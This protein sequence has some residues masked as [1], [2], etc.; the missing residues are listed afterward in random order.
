MICYSPTG[1]TKLIERLRED[2]DIEAKFWGDRMK[3]S[4]S[5]SLMTNI[6]RQQWNLYIVAANHAI[7][8]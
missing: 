8:C 5:V 3:E 4:L 1:A 7:I 2:Y 6:W